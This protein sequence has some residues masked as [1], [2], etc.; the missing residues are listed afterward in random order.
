MST[1][2]DVPLPWSRASSTVLATEGSRPRRPLDSSP[3]AAVRRTLALLA[4]GDVDVVARLAD[5]AGLDA[6]ALAERLA[7]HHVALP[8]ER[9]MRSWAQ[10]QQQDGD[11]WAVT[12]TLPT[13][14]TTP[15]TP[16]SAATAAPPGGGAAVRMELTRGSCGWRVAV[17]DVSPRAAP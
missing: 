9:P 13:T 14:P 12:A 11:R 2:D 16:A 8:H 17:L 7:R 10:V 3:E 5:G 6:L 1:I 4:D 15:A